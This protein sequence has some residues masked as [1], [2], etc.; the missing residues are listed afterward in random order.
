MLC[1]QSGSETLNFAGIFKY[2]YAKWKQQTN[3]FHLYEVYIFLKISDGR[4]EVMFIM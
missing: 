4:S 1:P 2:N 3:I